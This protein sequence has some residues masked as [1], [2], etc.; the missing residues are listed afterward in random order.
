[1]APV[2]FLFLIMGFAETLEN[3][4]IRNDLTPLQFR[5]HDNSPRSTVCA[6]SHKRKSFSE[7]TLFEIF[8]LLYVDDGAFAFQ[9]RKELELGSA[10]VCRQFSRFGLEM[11][12][13]NKDKAS[14][15][16]AVF[17]PPPG[18]FKLLSLPTSEASAAALPLATKPKQ[19]H[20][21]KR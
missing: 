21:S 13:G 10:V 5:R 14:K 4:W 17:F 15:T 18:F 7:G 12:V 1:M 9:S 11:H 20:E 6:T 16:E 8:C 19:E 2:L 3:E